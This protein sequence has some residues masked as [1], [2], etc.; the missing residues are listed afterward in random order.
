MTP[1]H[2][3]ENGNRSWSPARPAAAASSRPRLQVIINVI[4]RGM[5]IA[6]AVAAPR[7]HHQWLPDESSPS[8][9][10][11]GETIVRLE[12]RGHKVSPAPP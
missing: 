8:A 7:I 9:R 3:G 5:N 10:F 12:T 4:D 11:P 6:Q 2:V 1:D